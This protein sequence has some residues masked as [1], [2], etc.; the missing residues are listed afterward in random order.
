MITI[1]IV[2]FLTALT[3]F[4]IMLATV[5]GYYY[6]NNR[7]RRKYPY[8]KW[9]TLLKRLGAVN[10][11]NVA[12]IARDLIDESGQR[13]T[14]EDDLDL[15][16]SQ[17]WDLIGGMQGLHVLELNCAVLVDLV[18]YVQQWYPEALVIA[19]QLRQNTREI[20]WHIGRL[21]GAEKNGRLDAAFGDYAQRAVAIYFVMTRRVLSVYE[22]L[23]L[24]GL[25][26]LQQAL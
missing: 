19:E 1:R 8:G 3:V 24:P 4:V 2:Y 22:Q 9:E 18:F 5:A 6:L 13:R 23:D 17:I 10:K 14:D 16:P 15:E 21:K 26:E 25:A 7:K 11:D 12:L 20:E